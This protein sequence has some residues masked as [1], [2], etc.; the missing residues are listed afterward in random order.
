M[1]KPKTT[2]TKATKPDTSYNATSGVGSL[3]LNDTVVK[4]NSTVYRLSGY[5]G[6]TPNQL[7]NKSPTDYTRIAKPL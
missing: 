2:Y 1:A 7:N 6:A 4:L 5:N 3:L